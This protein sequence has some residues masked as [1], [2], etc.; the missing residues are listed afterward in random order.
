MEYNVI[1]RGGFYVGKFI[2]VGKVDGFYICIELCCKVDN[3]DVVFFVFYCCFFVNCF[4]E[5]FCI[6]MFLLLLNF[7]LILVYVYCYCFK[8]ILKLLMILLLI[9]YVLQQ[10]EDEMKI[11]LK[12]ENKICVYF[13]VY[14]EVM[15]RKGYKVGKFIFYGK[16]NFLD[17]CVDFCCGWF[18]CD[19]IFMFLNN[20]FMV[21]CFSGVV[22]EIVLV[23]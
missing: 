8:L 16:V 23:R 1:F 9:N 12:S 7:N 22:C 21:L 4:D 14:E 3:C 15:L 10:I 11:K 2:D 5:Y 19:L 20:C 18:C 6:F 13:E 17:Q